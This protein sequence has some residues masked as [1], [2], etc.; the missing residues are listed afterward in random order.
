MVFKGDASVRIGGVEVEERTPQKDL[1]LIVHSS[2]TWTS[3]AEFRCGKVV[4]V[5]HLI[6]RIIGSSADS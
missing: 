4:K 2:L 6:R 1:G 5:F 3:Q